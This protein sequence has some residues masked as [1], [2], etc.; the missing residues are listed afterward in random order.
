MDTNSVAAPANVGAQPKQRSK[1]RQQA[2]SPQPLA[3]D[4]MKSQ[5]FWAHQWERNG[6]PPALAGS[7]AKVERTL[8][9]LST[10]TQLVNGDETGRQWLDS[11][12]AA[13]AGY[14][15]LDDHTTAALCDAQELLT[16]SALGLLE[17]LQK[18]GPQA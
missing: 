2:K 15:P 5:E 11:G 3:A 13:Y 17:Q 4:A 14:A 18:R 6:F 9:A 1:P 10:I 16:E 12:N 7:L 8:C